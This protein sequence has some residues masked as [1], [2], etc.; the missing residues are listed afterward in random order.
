M[1]PGITEFVGRA[2]EMGVGDERE[3]GKGKGGGGG[4]VEEG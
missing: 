1:D 2:G 3:Q 4:G